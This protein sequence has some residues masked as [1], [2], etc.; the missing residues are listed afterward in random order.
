M[1]GTATSGRDSLT[2]AVTAPA[3]SAVGGAGAVPSG[4]SSGLA[5]PRSAA[6]LGRPVPGRGSVRAPALSPRP[7]QRPRAAARPGAR[8]ERRQVS[9]RFVPEPV[10]LGCPA[11]PG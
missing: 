6:A 7:E 9:G 3:R 10:V 4:G 11:R 5:R 1:P 2:A 8:L